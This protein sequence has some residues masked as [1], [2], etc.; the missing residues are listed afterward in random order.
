MAS[1]SKKT[2][3]LAS[4]SLTASIGAFLYITPYLSLLDFKSAVENSN[5]PKANQYINFPS[6]RKSLKVQIKD[7]LNI[8]YAKEIRSSPYAAF[9]LVLIEP[10][11][12]NIV[13]MTVTANGLKLLIEKGLLTSSEPK[14][15]NSKASKKKN[16]NQKIA[17]TK[18]NKSTSKIHLYYSNFNTFILS[19]KVEQAKKPIITYWKRKGPFK[20]RLNSLSIPYEL[21]KIN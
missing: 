15:V 5:Y 17:K 4:L 6:V 1:I 19:S 8:A 14:T 21:L 9:G 16:T 11:V 10:I 13:D 2:T 3:V 12:N 7:N 20:W 18:P